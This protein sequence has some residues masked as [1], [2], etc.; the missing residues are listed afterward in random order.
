[1]SKQANA[2]S[3][4]NHARLYYHRSGRNNLIVESHGL[5]WLCPLDLG[6]VALS[7]CHLAPEIGRS[8]AQLIPLPSSVSQLYNVGEL[9]HEAAKSPSRLVPLGVALGMLKRDLRTMQVACATG[10]VRG[11]FKQKRLWVATY[12]AWQEWAETAKRG[13]PE[14]SS[15]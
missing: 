12:E 8:P 3:P 11:A 10:K 5:Y 9:I 4:H 7:R 6:K 14:K 1:M 2:P 15:V 13:R